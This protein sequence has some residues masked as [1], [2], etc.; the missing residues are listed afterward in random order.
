VSA[1]A[2]VEQSFR[3]IRTALSGTFQ[4]NIM[5][6]VLW[7]LGSARRRVAC[8]LVMLLLVPAGQALAAAASAADQAF[9][10]KHLADLV[11]VE[12]IPI[13]TLAVD[14]VIAEPIFKLKIT[15][16]GEMT[17]TELVAKEGD[18]IAVV[19]LPSSDADMPKLMKLISPKFTLKSDQDGQAFQEALDALYPISD[20]D[21]SKLKSVK[22]DGNQWTFIRGKFFSHF[23]GF[24]VTTDDAGKITGIKYSLE[25]K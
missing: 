16:G 10:N 6:S 18:K 4:E 24:V 5:R 21:D 25:I 14:K 17:T 20:D 15:I 1:D 13:H 7:C 8:G 3:R 22:H 19:S 23:L 11:Q 9:F 2:G 12:P